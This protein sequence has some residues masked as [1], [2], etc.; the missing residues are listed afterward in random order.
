MKTFEEYIEEKEPNLL[1]NLKQFKMFY[2]IDDLINSYINDVVKNN[3]V[4]DDVIKRAFE[5][6]RQREPHPDW[7][8]IYDDYEDY[9]KYG[10]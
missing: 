9:K 7:D 2:F 4:L 6:G 1:H 3:S 5:A 8:F 10:L